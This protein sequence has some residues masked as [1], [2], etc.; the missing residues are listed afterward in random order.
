MTNFE[1]WYAQEFPDLLT[2]VDDFRAEFQRAYEAGAASQAGT[3]RDE[4][5]GKAMAGLCAGPKYGKSSDAVF[6]WNKGIYAARSYL[7]ADAMLEARKTTKG[8]D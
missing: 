8:D 6:T 5:A 3:L 7:I 1:K 2:S 4:F